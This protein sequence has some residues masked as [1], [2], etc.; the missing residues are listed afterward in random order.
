MV[1]A[2]SRI[3]L[4]LTIKSVEA[5]KDGGTRITN[6]GTMELEGTRPPGAR[7]RNDRRQLRLSPIGRMTRAG[8]GLG[9]RAI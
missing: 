5:M 7:R 4:R 3:R 6:E 2:G 1:P 8:A 9:G